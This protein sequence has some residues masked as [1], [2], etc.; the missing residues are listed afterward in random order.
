MILVVRSI[1]A[2]L[3]L[4]HGNTGMTMGNIMKLK[5]YLIIVVYKC[6]ISIIF[7][8]KFTGGKTYT[9]YK[10]IDFFNLSGV[11]LNLI[12]HINKIP[13]CEGYVLGTITKFVENK[14]YFYYMGQGTVWYVKKT[15][16]YKIK[17]VSNKP[18]R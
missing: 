17:F 15:K 6:I 4:K 9:E 11:Y 8:I 3:L 18:P 10:L 13:S 7:V 16:K 12:K 2:H 5:F 14:T 1:N